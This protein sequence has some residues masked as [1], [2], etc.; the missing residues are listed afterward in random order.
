MSKKKKEKLSHL[1]RDGLPDNIQ[2]EDRIILEEA[3]YRTQLK[4]SQGAPYTEVA[5]RIDDLRAKEKEEYERSL[6]AW[7]K[8]KNR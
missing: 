8:I 7:N 2:G 4:S 6:E 1:D 5:D 3:I